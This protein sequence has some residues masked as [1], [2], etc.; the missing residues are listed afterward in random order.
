MY[1]IMCFAIK[2]KNKAKLIMRVAMVVT[3]IIR[4]NDGL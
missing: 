4:K 2:K 1:I 3:I